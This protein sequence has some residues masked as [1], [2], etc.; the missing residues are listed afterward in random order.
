MVVGFDIEATHSDGQQAGSGIV[1]AEFGL[2][3]GCMDDLRQPSKGGVA[4][5]AEVLDEDLETALAVPVRV[6]RTR[7]VE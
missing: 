2:N 7:G 4:P 3:I 1:G 6:L 5:Q